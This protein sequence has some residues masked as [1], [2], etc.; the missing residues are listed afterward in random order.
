MTGARRCIVLAA[1]GTGGHVFP[2]RALAEELTARG[3]RLVLITDRRGGDIGGALPDM[4]T[5]RINA[6]SPAGGARSKLEGLAQLGMGVLQARALLRRI[7]PDAVVG[8]GG[9]P[10]VPTVW[11][12]T[13]MRLATLIHEQNAV[14]G[15]A[16]RLLA[17]RSDRI[18]TSFAEIERVR[19]Q[20]VVKIVHTGN[21]VR[22]A[23]AAI[24]ALPYP[25]PANGAGGFNLLVIGGSLGARIMSDVVP[26]AIARL[27]RPARERLSVVQQCR[28]EDL[29][30]VQKI[31]TD[32][33]VEFRLAPFFDDMPACLGAAHLVISRAGASSV[34]ELAA[35]GRPAILVPYA[36]AADDHQSANARSAEQAGGAW[37]MPE[38]GF[39]PESAAVRIK[40]LLDRPDELAAAAERQRGAGRSDAAARL[41]DAV[42]A[43]AGPSRNGND[44]GATGDSPPREAAA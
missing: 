38:R 33:G 37:M 35:A 43:L 23:I 18:A 14:M 17:P 25:D 11:A 5:H 44:D 8:F 4:E 41:A 6:A 7:A 28:P 1:G 40:T 13:R 26:A 24:G 42:E 9:Y 29:E 39:S 32:A 27:T 19:P 15:R 3:N 36:H 20:D 34:A 21:P 30:P 22:E 12:A 2:A 16:N 10:S 31:Y